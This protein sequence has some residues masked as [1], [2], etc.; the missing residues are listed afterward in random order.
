VLASFT[1]LTP[2]GGLLALVV[3]L[4]IAAFARSSAR[5]SRLRALLGLERPQTGSRLTFAMLAAVPLLLGLAATGPAL[6]DQTERRIR[7]DAQA[8]FVFDISRSMLASGRRGAPTRLA[9]ATSIAIRLRN[10]AIGEVPSGVATVTTLLLPHLF[11]TSDAAVFDSTVMSTVSSEQPPPPYLAP[12]FPG[13]SFSALAPLRDQGYFSPLTKKRVVVLLTDGES[14]P[15][16]VQALAQTLVG[17]DYSQPAPGEANSPSQAPISLLII[18]VGSPRDRI[19]H[20][21]GS[22][23]AA[24]RP[25][26]RTNEIISA[27]AADTGARVFDASELPAAENELRRV[28]GSGRTETVGEETKTRSLGPYLALAAIAAVAVII[29]KRN[30]A[31]I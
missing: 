11:P 12:G 2:L 6:R 4:P 18:R 20:S 31:S 30:L 5:A 27:L 28:I 16:E 29:G 26:P 7:T 15:Y 9:Q 8:V 10:D 24:Y 19:Y 21:N 14:G 13:T 25:D 3:V 22:V 23:E 1:F 17:P